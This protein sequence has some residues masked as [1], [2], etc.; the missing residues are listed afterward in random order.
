MLQA[1]VYM[2]IA[3]CHFRITMTQRFL[4]KAQILRG[5]I[6]IRPATVAEDMAGIAGVLQIT[7]FEGLV[8]DITDTVA[9]YAS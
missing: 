1:L 6:K 5:L 2:G 4:N 9:R 7:G 3:G 8:H